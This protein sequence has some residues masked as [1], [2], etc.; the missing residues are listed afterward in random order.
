[1]F[2][3]CVIYFLLPLSLFYF[4]PLS[5]VWPIARRIPYFMSPFCFI[6]NPPFILPPNFYFQKSKF[7]LDADLFL[8]KKKKKIPSYLQN[9]DLSHMLLNCFSSLIYHRNTQLR[10]LFH[11]INNVLSHSWFCSCCSLSRVLSLIINISY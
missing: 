2:L 9:Q 1:M 4:G 7:N 11:Q 10:Q 6:S 5:S 8:K 3:T